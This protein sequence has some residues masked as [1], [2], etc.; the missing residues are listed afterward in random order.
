MDADFREGGINTTVRLQSEFE[1]TCECG[2]QFATHERE[3]VCKTCG[4]QIVVR[5]N[6]KDEVKRK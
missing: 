2:A 1:I 3:V 5:W 4:R 6:E